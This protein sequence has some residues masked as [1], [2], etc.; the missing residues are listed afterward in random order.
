M[1]DS[2]TLFRPSFLQFESPVQHV[3]GRDKMQAFGNLR[4]KEF[5][6]QQLY[7]LVVEQF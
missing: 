2:D 7:C 3:P 6:Y 1:L 4:R 5:P